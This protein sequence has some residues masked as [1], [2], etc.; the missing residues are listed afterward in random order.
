MHKDEM[1]EEYSSQFEATKEPIDVFIS[2]ARSDE[3]VAANHAELLRSE[4]FEV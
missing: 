2:Y 1:N 4:G 3:K